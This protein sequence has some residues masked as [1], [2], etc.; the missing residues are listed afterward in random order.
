MAGNIGFAEYIAGLER[1]EARLEKQLVEVRIALAHAQKAQGGPSLRPALP[2]PPPAIT[3]GQPKRVGKFAGMSPKKAALAFLRE[4][5]KP[6]TTVEIREALQRGGVDSKAKQFHL[7]LYNTLFRYRK[8]GDFVNYGEGNW[9]LPE[10]DRGTPTYL[11][12]PP[13]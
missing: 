3:E 5:G 8:T 9:G 4:R 10:W 7:T 2:E 12:P 13:G 11:R 1:D 6:A